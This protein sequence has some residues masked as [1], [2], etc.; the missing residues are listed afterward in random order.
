MSDLELGQATIVYEDPDGG[1]TRRTLDNEQVVYVRDHW[2]VKAGTDDQGN[3]LMHQ[4][5]RDRVHHVERNVE[6][7]EEEASTVGHRLRSFA[8]ELGQKLPVGSEERSGDSD[9]EPIPV[10]TREENRDPENRS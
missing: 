7:F 2:T 1:L 10:D 5:P 9:V 4:I 6:R 3:D 8:S